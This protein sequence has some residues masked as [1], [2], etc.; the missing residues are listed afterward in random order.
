MEYTADEIDTV[1]RTNF[2]SAYHLCQLFQPQLAES[3]AGAIVNIG[4]VSG[5]PS[6]TNTGSVY[7]A[8]KSGLNGMTRSLAAEWGPANVRVNC[9]APWYIRTPLTEGVLADE[10]YL[11]KVIERTPMRRVGQPEEVAAVVSALCSPGF[12]YVTGQV[13]SVDGGFECS[14]F[15]Y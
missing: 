8:L 7:G 3:G 12:S 15:G 2:L 1:L 6:R 4:S 11:A 9:V 14:G 13:I 5:G 10:E